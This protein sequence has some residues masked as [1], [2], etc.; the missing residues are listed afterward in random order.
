RSRVAPSDADAVK[1]LWDEEW[2]PE[3]DEAV[4]GF[5]EGLSEL[6]AGGAALENAVLGNWP[7]GI[8]SALVIWKEQVK[9]PLPFSESSADAESGEEATEANL[10]VYSELK[11]AVASILY[12]RNR[13][14]GQMEAIRQTQQPK[15]KE[16]YG[17]LHGQLVEL[18]EAWKSRLVDYGEDLQE[19]MAEEPTPAAEK[20]VPETNEQDGN[21]EA[22]PA[23]EDG[24]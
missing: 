23:K 8:E 11:K 13:T 19:A 14:E 16:A 24:E 12:I 17:S 9:M 1:A 22:S 18:G 3:L 6:E 2:A 4:A 20:E 21:A 10:A 7:K 15:L 5:V